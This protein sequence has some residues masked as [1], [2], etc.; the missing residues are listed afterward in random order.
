MH[1]ERLK[2]ILDEDH[3]GKVEI[4]GKAVVSERYVE[5]TLVSNPRLDSRMM[6]E[7]IFGP[8]LPIFSFKDI[9]EVIKFV[10]DRPKPLVLYY[11]GSKNCDKVQ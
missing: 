5:P 11:F 1:T 3:G 4:G 8:I 6:K 10:N 9:N 2:Q 7:E